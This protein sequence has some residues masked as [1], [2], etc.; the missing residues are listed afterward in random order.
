[1][2]SPFHSFCG[3]H[4]AERSGGSGPLEE[5]ALLWGASR[6]SFFHSEL[7]SSQAWGLCPQ[8]SSHRTS[9]LES[10]SLW[11]SSLSRVQSE[12]RTLGNDWLLHNETTFPALM[13]HHRGL[14]LVFKQK[15]K[16]QWICSLHL[17]PTFQNSWLT[18]Q[19][20]PQHPRAS[21]Y[22]VLITRKRNVAFISIP[23]KIL[24]FRRA[25]KINICLK[26]ENEISGW[27]CNFEIWY[28]GAQEM[29]CK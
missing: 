4:T 22:E 3:L 2:Y 15:L 8:D 26:E 20:V 9:A 27:F 25:G 12:G 10:Q 28:K 5:L 7:T 24:G 13:P 23:P 6:E 19:L 21:H 17:D 14:A 11:F 16:T 1:M 29:N 18:P